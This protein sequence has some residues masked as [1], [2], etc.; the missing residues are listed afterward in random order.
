MDFDESSLMREVNSVIND[1]IK[2]IHHYWTAD[3]YANKELHS[4]MKITSIDFEFDYEQNYADKI[5]LAV[6]IP[7]GTYAKRIYPFKEH[8]DIV[9]HKKPL[10][11]GADT[12]DISKGKESER[13]TATILDKGNPM[14]EANA[15]FTATEEAL[16]ISNLID[17]EFQLVN[18]SLE[19]IR[20]ITI[21]GIYRNATV[22]SVIRA[23]MTNESKKVVVDGIRKPKG[24][25]MVPSNN[26]AK[27]DHIIIPQGTKLTSVPEYLHVKCGGVY[28]A[29]LG[30]Y[31]LG[32]FW[33]VYPCYDTTRFNKSKR[34][35]TVINVPTNKFPNIERTYKKV[36]SNLTVLATGESRFI[37][38]SE[39][40]Q[41]SHGN[42]VRFSNASKFMDGFSQTKNNKTTLS[43]GTNNNEFVSEQ[44]QTGNNVVYSS[45]NHI[46]ANPYIEYSKLARRQGNVFSF[47][48]E[49]SNT[50]LLFPG[51]VAR[52]LY[53][54]DNGISDL[55][56]VVL[57]VHTY[58]GL[59]GVGMT[60]G[61]HTS[62]TM[63]SI[64]VKRK[65]E[66]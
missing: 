20:M 30:Y 15:P 58:I 27:R 61:S 56:G 18:K 4:A 1:G 57:K 53:M 44:R 39:K 33:Y 46:N 63:I 23:V 19:Q 36:G 24:V 54:N 28:T 59:K 66:S 62:R 8:I 50:S 26:T 25:D 38:D 22:E 3:I 14:I 47:I 13:Y 60:S 31:L 40:L 48:W 42:G 43:R 34:T 64:F 37:D 2:P 6:S 11:E 32:D 7:A 12:T 51:M 55:Y 45:D 17:V 29:G 35:L 10:I 9:L 21:G 16:N 49:N 41:L 65:Q 5:I 52:V